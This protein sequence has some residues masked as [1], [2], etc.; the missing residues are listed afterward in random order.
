MGPAKCKREA[1]DRVWLKAGTTL[2]LRQMNG[3][4][5]GAPFRRRGRW[6]NPR[7]S[8]LACFD[9]RSTANLASSA[10]R[11]VDRTAPTAA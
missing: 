9:Q 8:R 11:M 6:P 4:N 3:T 10:S 5:G 2:R 1:S 7:A